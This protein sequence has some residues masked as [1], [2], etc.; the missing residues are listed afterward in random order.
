MNDLVQKQSG[1]ISVIYC[2]MGGT[3]CGGASINHQSRFTSKTRKRTRRS[4]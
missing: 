3:S 1:V 4:I 2:V